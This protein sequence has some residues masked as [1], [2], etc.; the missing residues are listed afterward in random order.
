[1]NLKEE[2]SKVKAEIKQI[3]ENI[4]TEKSKLHTKKEKSEFK[5][6]EHK[7]YDKIYINYGQKAYQKYVPSKYQ[8]RNIMYLLKEQRFLELYNKHGEKVFKKYIKEIQSADIEYET[9]S[10]TKSL[11][12]KMKHL[13]MKKILPNA[14]AITLA[15]PTTIGISSNLQQYK[16]KKEYPKE[17]ENYI[18]EINQYGEQVKSYNLSDLQNIMK[19]MDDMWNNIQGYGEPQIDLLSYPGLDLADKDGVGVC[20][21]MADDVA[22]KLN[23]INEEY[24]ARS[25]VV[26]MKSGNYALAD[27]ERKEV[28]EPEDETEEEQSDDEKHWTIDFTRMMGNHAVVL[29][30]IPN[31][32]IA[33]VVDPTNPGIGIFQNGKITMFNSSQYSK[34]DSLKLS[35]KPA[36]ASAYGLDSFL[37]SANNYIDSIGLQDIKKLESKF[38]VEAQNKALEEVRNICPKSFAESIHY[39]IKTNTATISQS[40]NQEQEQSKDRER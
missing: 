14:T 33:L 8:K 31:E 13:W 11:L 12:Y 16:E 22:R 39:D 34:K 2:K 17:I 25:L 19:V 32:N 23:A 18:D 30:D 3:Q 7:E 26:Y 37:K 36:G 5:E 38:G 35:V 28:E 10:Y 6:K 1:M 40:K 20:R 24:N 21:N 29:M 9:G 4:K 27:I 15:L